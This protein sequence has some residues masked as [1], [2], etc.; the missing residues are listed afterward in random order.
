MLFKNIQFYIKVR[1]RYC[2]WW[3]IWIIYFEFK[4][5][6]VIITYTSKYISY[7]YSKCIIITGILFILSIKNF[8]T[9][10]NEIKMIKFTRHHLLSFLRIQQSKSFK[11][12]RNCKIIKNINL[13]RIGIRIMSTFLLVWLMI[14]SRWF[15]AQNVFLIYTNF[16][17]TYTLLPFYG[18]R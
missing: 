12:K 10:Y 3:I 4:K 18:S 13:N 7:I 9:A 16:Y 1:L 8:Y 11:R 6:G 14:F 15:Y 5:C 2:F 17:F